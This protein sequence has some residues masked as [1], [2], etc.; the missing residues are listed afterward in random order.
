MRLLGRLRLSFPFELAAVVDNDYVRGGVR[1]SQIPQ[2]H[3][4]LE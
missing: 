1:N 4:P 2:L 3:L